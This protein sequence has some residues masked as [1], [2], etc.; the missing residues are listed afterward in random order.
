ML[1]FTCLWPLCVQEVL[2][3]AGC[4]GALITSAHCFRWRPGT[5]FPL[6][7]VTGCLSLSVGLQYPPCSLLDLFLQCFLK[8]PF[9]I[10]VSFLGRILME[11]AGNTWGHVWERHDVRV[12]AG[13]IPEGWEL[14]TTRDRDLYWIYKVRKALEVIIFFSSSLVREMGQSCLSGRLMWQ[15]FIK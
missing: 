1:F 12:W 7:L 8:K 3:S 4:Q 15:Q 10:A 11:T 13:L 14:E 2:V 6:W 5:S 9:E